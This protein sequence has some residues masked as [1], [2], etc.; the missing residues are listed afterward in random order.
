MLRIF[1]LGKFRVEL[2]GELLSETA[3]ARRKAKNLLKL[4]ALQ[5]G[6]RI[7]KDQAT[8]VLWPDL[9]PISAS[10]NLYR[11]LHLLRQTLQPGQS[12]RAES[13][14]IILKEEIIR[15]NTSD[16]IWIDI[17]A[18]QSL[19]ERALNETDATA[20]LEEAL[21]LY[22]GDLLEEDLYEE[23]TLRR[24]EELR[25]AHQQNLLQL[26]GL[27][28]KRRKYAHAVSLLQRILASE[29]TNESA[30][31]ELILNF[32]LAGQRSEALSQYQR[33]RK[34]LDE[35]VGLDPSPETLDL[36]QQVLAGEI[37]ADL[38]TEQPAELVTLSPVESMPL[39]QVA[40]YCTSNLPV[41]LTPIV[42]R[43]DEIIQ[44]ISLLSSTEGRLLTLTGPAGV[45]KTRTAIQIAHELFKDGIFEQGVTF[46]ALATLSDPLQLVAAI[47]QAT[48][49]KE[50]GGQ[51]LLNLIKYQLCDYQMLLVLDNFEQIIAATGVVHELL[52]AC[53]NLKILVTSRSLLHLYGEYELVVK[54]LALPP[55]RF[56]LS[57]NELEDY[58][59]I[60]LFVKRARAVK[61]DFQLTTQ[62]VQVIA[63]IC[64][65]LD[66]LPLALELV[67]ARIKHLSPEIILDR[68]T[69]WL[70]QANSS[71]RHLPGRQQ[72]LHN[73]LEWS[74]NLLE[75]DER[76]LFIRLGVFRQGCTLEAIEKVC[77]N[78][79]PTR[80]NFVTE[81][82]LT[83]APELVE[84]VFAL[85]DKSLL[86]RQEIKL[87]RFD[88]LQNE[89]FKML[90]IV[91][92]HALER[93]LE[94]GD[95]NLLRARHLDFFLALA[96]E[97]E[98]KMHSSS[99]SSLLGWLELERANLLA[100]LE[101]SIGQDEIANDLL[102]KGL[103]LAGS[104]SWFWHQRGYW[105]EGKY[106]LDKALAL[107]NERAIPD[108]VMGKVLYAGGL[109]NL[110]L[111]NPLKANEMLVESLR[112]YR[113]LGDKWGQAHALDALGEMAR[114]QGNYAVAQ[115]L[116]KAS[117]GLCNE[118]D[119]QF[120]ANHEVI[121][122]GYVSYQSGD[123]SQARELLKQGFAAAQSIGDRSGAARALNGLGELNRRE[124][125]Y[126]PAAECYQQ[127][128]T[129]Y[130]DLGQT[131]NV[132]LLLHNLGQ[133]ELDQLNYERAATFFRSSL[134]LGYEIKSKRL[135]AWGLAGMAGA[136]ARANLNQAAQLLGVVEA[137]LENS[138]AKLDPTNRPTYERELAALKT[139]L[140]DPSFSLA[141]QEGRNLSMEQAL[142]I[143]LNQ[144]VFSFQAH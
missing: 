8:E 86:D 96:E 140:P 109:M 54:P 30:H 88:Q 127:S 38:P 122:L 136:A 110:G 126:S 98:P 115:P 82:H 55:A 124:G 104:L 59:A 44:G 1:L 48:E 91:R 62:N 24:R 70:H 80:L 43:E 46:V 64:Q 112:I 58:P 31:R 105:S 81:G 103:R 7:H 34:V 93:L 90:E 141:W 32:T 139:R 66:G 15:L 63:E 57:V 20:V 65:R 79:S 92:E 120:C 135:I 102:E 27:Y 87:A 6:Y 129:L 16:G 130:R 68:L 22:Q 21:N 39:T 97:S 131:G 100:A 76:R 19:L 23:W 117:L 123:Y 142:T 40:S 25:Q 73:A 99:L 33:C 74:Y 3:W 53:P 138:G 113:H 128:L 143:V 2:N 125:E 41:P 17:D 42:G 114:Q 107:S 28:R 51:P 111:G 13:S 69:D 4:L 106:W 108:V 71:S 49:V 14:Y 29:P 101:W 144:G 5:P 95:V 35:E 36:Y 75:E 83:V 94:S 61:A 12:P 18:F 45:G 116:Y 118:L 9:D 72:T 121:G 47:A 132:V 119:D 56:F 89:R 133:L 134:A 50:A 60:T 137:L 10:S 77:G 85:V 84:Q 11:N 67:A 37:K 78:N 26:A 52:T